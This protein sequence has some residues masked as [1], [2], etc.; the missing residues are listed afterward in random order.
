VPLRQPFVHRRRHRKAGIAI[1]RAEV[2]HVE[3][4]TLPKGKRIS[5]PILNSSPKPC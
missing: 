5:A 4:G 1:N 2:T 3:G